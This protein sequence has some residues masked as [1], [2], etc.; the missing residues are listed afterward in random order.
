MDDA[1][2]GWVGKGAV[3]LWAEAMG[4]TMSKIVHSGDIHSVHTAI[5]YRETDVPAV[6]TT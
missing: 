5:H 2:V 3:H 4:C 1:D 6:I